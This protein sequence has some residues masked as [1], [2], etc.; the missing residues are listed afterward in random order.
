L[1]TW[2]MKKWLENLDEKKKL[3]RVRRDI[4][5]CIYMRRIQKRIDRELDMLLLLCRDYPNVFNGQFYNEFGHL[6]K[7]NPKRKNERF[8]KLLQ[9][10]KALNFD[11]R[12]ILK[13][14]EREEEVD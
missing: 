2:R 6:L 14:L 3:G 7:K 1:I 11:V 12:L 9:V 10:L 8:R 4:V 13:D 5:Y